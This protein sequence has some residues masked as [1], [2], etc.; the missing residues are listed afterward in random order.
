[1]A[2][3]PTSIAELESLITNTASPIVESAVQSLEAES[4]AQAE[5]IDEMQRE[6]LEKIES[7]QDT[8]I[9]QM[10]EAASRSGT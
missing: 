1:M 9:F 3:L 8:L 7:V 5:R 2:S 6:L 4:T 10:A